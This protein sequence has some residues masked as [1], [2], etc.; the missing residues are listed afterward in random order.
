[1]D[2]QNNNGATP[3]WLAAEEGRTATAEALME[4]GGDVNH[5]NKSGS[6]PLHFA[7][8]KGH[9]DTSEAL[10]ARGADV[11]TQVRRHGGQYVDTKSSHT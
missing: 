8:G 7:A 5:R 2:L 9:T 6:S 3:L 1:M 4:A 11:N 10:L